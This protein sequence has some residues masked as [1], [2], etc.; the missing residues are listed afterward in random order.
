[1][2]AEPRELTAFVVDFR[3]AK[4]SDFEVGLFVGLHESDE[5]AVIIDMDGR[6]VPPPIWQYTDIHHRGCLIVRDD[7]AVA[8]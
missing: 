5:N 7:R 2:A 6:V 8:K 3:R 1:M 4:G